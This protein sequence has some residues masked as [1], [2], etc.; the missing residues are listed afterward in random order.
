MPAF[1]ETS[2]ER[3]ITCHPDLIRLFERV[4]R[5]FDCT[6]LCGKREKKEQ[7]AAFNAKPQKSKTPWPKS[8]HNTTPSSAVDVVP[9]PVVW[10]DKYK[11]ISTFTKDVARFYLFAGY[12]KGVAD[13]MGIKL[14]WGGDW[15]GTWDIWE[16]SFDDLPHFELAEIN[17]VGTA[18]DG[19]PMID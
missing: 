18:V 19:G 8:K 1:G 13:E 15:K 5:E 16:N 3:L 7:D 17:V 14:R 2:K 10:P 11:R 12:V 9:Y 6:V 4:V